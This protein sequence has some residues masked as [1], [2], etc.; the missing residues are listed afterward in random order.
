MI[1]SQMND[2]CIM[3]YNTDK[4]KRTKGTHKTNFNVKKEIEL[5][6][7]DLIFFKKDT[8]DVSW[9]WKVEEITETR[10]STLR[11]YNYVETMCSFISITDNE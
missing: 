2:V 4:S 9:Y 6:I 11:D 8:L 3:W 1:H 5:N 7:G 10:Q